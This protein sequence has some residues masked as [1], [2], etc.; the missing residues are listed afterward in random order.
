MRVVNLISAAALLL[1][2]CSAERIVTTD[3]PFVESPTSTTSEPPA[4]PNRAHLVDAFDYVAHPAGAAVY[5]FTTPSGR[6][7]CAIVPRDKAGCQSATSPQ[8]SMNITGEPDTVRNSAG[9]R[10][11]PNAIV[12]EREGDPRFA[13]LTKP[14]FVLDD[15]KVLDFNRVLAV[16]GFRCN[17]QDVGISCMSETTG[18]GFTFSPEEFRPRYT[19]VPANAR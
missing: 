7:A 3:E 2:G 4:P 8:S 19:E 15:A 16:A 10:A 18:K 12:I 13:A 11:T 9:E 6:W 5:F 1:A 14:E 17:V